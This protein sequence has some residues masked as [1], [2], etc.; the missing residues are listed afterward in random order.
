MVLPIPIPPS[1]LA[2]TDTI[3]SRAVDN[4][5]VETTV[6]SWGNTL[7]DHSKRWATD[8]HK[9]STVRIIKGIG[10]GQ[11]APIQGNSCS[12]L[13]IRG[14]W[15]SDVGAGSEYVILNADFAQILRDALGGG[16]NISVANPLQAHK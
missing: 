10:A 12:M 7:Q 14:T 1:G 15:L 11:S 8:I 4:G 2:S 6:P 5:F 9:N 3:K 16:A 13:V